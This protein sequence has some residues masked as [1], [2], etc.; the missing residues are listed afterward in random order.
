MASSKKP[1]TKNVKR[2]IVLKTCLVLTVTWTLRYQVMYAT[3]YYQPQTP[4]DDH[5][6]KAPFFENTSFDKLQERAV[7]GVPLPLVAYKNLQARTNSSSLSSLP[8]PSPPPIHNKNIVIQKD[9]PHKGARGPNG[10]WGYVHDPTIIR[11]KPWPFRVPPKEQLEICAPRPSDDGQEGI[12]VIVGAAALGDFV[13]THQVHVVSKKQNAN[14][15]S[16]KIFCAIYTYPGND[17][18]TDAIRETWGKRCDGFLAASHTTTIPEAATVR[19]PHY[20]KHTGGLYRGLWQKVR[21]MIGYLYD[22]FLDDYDFFHISGDDTFVILENLKAL[23]SSP[24]FVQ[25]AGGP[26]YPHP[27]YVGEWTHPSWLRKIRRI[28]AR[29]FTTWE[30]A[31]AI[32]L[33]EVRS[34]PLRKPSCPSVTMPRWIRRKICSWAS[35]CGST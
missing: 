8:P 5:A 27:T 31:P 17:P 25:H 35:A 1:T 30:V 26:G 29:S 6:P 3:I 20:G 28:I 21:S 32:P 2:C 12:G 34:K 10:E 14:K 18:L 4:Q 16:L 11:R 15:N 33:V 13:L 23:L 24:E 9:F 7:V 22:H 19:M